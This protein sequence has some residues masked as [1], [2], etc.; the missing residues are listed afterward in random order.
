MSLPA[1]EF[2][3]TAMTALGYDGNPGG[4]SEE[5]GLGAHGYQRVR[6]WLSGENEPDY[7]A[8]V[9]IAEKCGWLHTDGAQPSP[10]ADLEA[11]RRVAIRLADE[12]E[13]L[14]VILGSGRVAR[15]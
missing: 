11:A 9:L 7:E 8:T 2:V 14:A 15:G 5:L 12:A 3:K 13:Q 10:G 4:F 6:R 1:T